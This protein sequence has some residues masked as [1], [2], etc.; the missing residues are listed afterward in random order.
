[1][2]IAILNTKGG[3]AKTTSTVYLGTALSH[4][5]SCTAID[6]D[7]QGSLTDWHMDAA[8]NRTPLAFSLAT[9]NAAQLRRGVDL[10]SDY[11]LFDTPPGNSDVLQ[12][13]V[14][15]ADVAIIPTKPSPLDMRRMWLTHSAVSEQIP[16]LVLLVDDEKDTALSRQAHAAFEAEELAMFD[17]VIPHRQAIKKSGGERPNDLFGYGS[18]AAELLE[19]MDKINGGAK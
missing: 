8:E 17:T 6:T 5:G 9:A 19:I 18:V 10:A 4:Y 12:A 13:V 2:R 3:V 14:E 15:L 7:P 11:V 16:T 1:M